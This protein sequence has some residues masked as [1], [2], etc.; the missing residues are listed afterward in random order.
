MDTIY[1]PSNLLKGKSEEDKLYFIDSY[2]SSAHVLRA[3]SSEL[4]TKLQR[5]VMDSEQ[6]CDHSA[7]LANV[8]QRKA[9]RQ[10]IELLPAPI[11]EETHNV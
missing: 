1:V 7:M 5:L 11:N 9:L 2:K 3:I 8:G 10:L 6:L 4:E